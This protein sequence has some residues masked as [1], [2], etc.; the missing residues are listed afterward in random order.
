MKTLRYLTMAVATLLL[1]A[2]MDGEKSLFSYQ[3]NEW[4]EPTIV[5]PPYGNNNI[6]MTNIVTIAELKAHPTYKDAIANSTNKLV[7]DDLKL[8]VR[9][10]GNDIGGNLYKQFAAQDNTGAVIVAVNQ[11]GLCGYLA[12]GQEII[13]DLKGLYVG[14]YGNQFE[15]GQPYNGQIGR[16]SKDV[17]NTHFRLIGDIDA[18]AIRPIDF[19]LVKDA[20]NG[21]AG[22]LVVLKDVTFTNADGT[23][24][25]IDGAASG[26]NYVSQSIDGFSN[27]IIRTSTYADFASTVLPFNIE[28]NQKVPCTITGIATRYR[29]TW[30]IM[31]RKTS[32]L[33]Y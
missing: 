24:T 26:G 14:G 3:Y 12:E 18:N 29:D 15:I 1:T 9:V 10:T 19:N 13:I 16:M 28:T 8:R 11:G 7:T 33:S 25:L 27:V 17:W 22:R 31:I 6:D 4:D 21:N 32:D 23:K 20:I 5:N 2:C 30:Q